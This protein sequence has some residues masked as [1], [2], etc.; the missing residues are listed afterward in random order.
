MLRLAESEVGAIFA[1]KR[2][3]RISLDDLHQLSARIFSEC[4]SNYLLLANNLTQ[5]KNTT[6]DPHLT[7]NEKEA[8]MLKK[9]ADIAAIKSQIELLA[10]TNNDYI[11]LI[12]S[13]IYKSLSDTKSVKFWL[14]AV[15]SCQ[16][17]GN[18]FLGVCIMNCLSEANQKQKSISRF[19]T[20]SEI[21]QDLKAN[22]WDK[23]FFSPGYYRD[24][25]ASMNGD[26]KFIAPAFHNLLTAEEKAEGRE[27]AYGKVMHLRNELKLEEW[28]SLINAVKLNAEDIEHDKKSLTKFL[29]PLNK[30]YLVDDVYQLLNQYK[31]TSLEKL[32]KLFKTAASFFQQKE[33]DTFAASFRT[34]ISQ[35]AINSKTPLFPALSIIEPPR[36]RESQPAVKSVPVMDQTTIIAMANE[37]L[38]PREMNRLYCKIIDSFQMD[39]NGKFKKEF[40]RNINVLLEGR[41]VE[42]HTLVT[43]FPRENQ[44]IDLLRDQQLDRDALLR[45]LKHA[46][47]LQIAINNL[48]TTRINPEQY[49]LLAASLNSHILRMAHD[50]R[51]LNDSVLAKQIE[52]IALRAVRIVPAKH[53]KGKE[54]I[55]VPVTKAPA[56]MAVAKPKSTKSG[57]LQ[58]LTNKFSGLF[59]KS[60]SKDMK[61]ESNKNDSRPDTPESSVKSKK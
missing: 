21:Y 33:K 54:E 13:H 18:D 31:I 47:R 40:A 26:V 28:V 3:D 59:Y 29:E 37:I 36:P 34:S 4:M 39:K 15:R 45:E 55:D 14:N 49:N 17:N 43:P 44:I 52:D 24:R 58:G 30:A 35:N 27:D 38:T 60:K 61:A 7:G 48:R 9:K 50:A 10:K 51:K 2:V 16:Q 57:Q 56:R 11:A 42:K 22:Y 12:K 5:L 32:N 53:D 41:V 6:I 20:K 46:T 25:M 19:L 23:Y 1:K 8:A